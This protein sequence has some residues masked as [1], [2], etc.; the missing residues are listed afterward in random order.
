M[1]TARGPDMELIYIGDTM[2]SWC[3]AFAPVMDSIR[4]KYGDNFQYRIIVG[5]LRPGANAEE[6]T[7]RFRSFLRGEWKKINE[8]TGQPFDYAI[9]DHSTF[10]YDT[11]PADRAVVTMR[12]MKPDAEIDFF[13][14][15][16][17]AFYSENTDITDPKALSALAAEFGVDAADFATQLA[18]ETSD[19][20]A[21][22]DYAEARS[23]GIS[24]FPS[25]VIRDGEQ[26]GALTRGYQPFA[27]LEPTLDRIL[28]TRSLR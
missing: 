13:K 22:S 8:V 7:D 21:C 2:C 3:W 27:A 5:G 20:V 14:R 19:A 6:L 1:F 10:R 26:Y 18:S 25:V 9:L 12:A 23:L 17:R 28:S 24:G 11:H 16:Q 4:A 15:I